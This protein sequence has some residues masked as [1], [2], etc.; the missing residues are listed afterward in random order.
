MMI[1]KNPSFN[2]LSKNVT[3]R[4]GELV[5][6]GIVL[7]TAA[8]YYMGTRGLPDRSMIYA[9][10]LMYAT[11]GLAVIT[12]L[13]HA[14]VLEESRADGAEARDVQPDITTEPTSD[15]QEETGGSDPHFNRVT[16]TI[17]VVAT[18]VYIVGGAFF[19]SFLTPA[20]FIGLTSVFLG[21]VLVVFGERR[22]SRVVVYSV[23]FSLFIYGI[24]VSWLEVPLI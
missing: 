12:I 8:L 24:F 6:P 21:A 17:Y 5:F 18:I 7:V 15:E 14:V 9:G 20:I 10:P 23:G 1:P 13:Q 4:L 3:L 11:A 16:A 22:V 2:V 19:S